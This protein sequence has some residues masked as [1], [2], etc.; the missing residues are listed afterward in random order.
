M[1]FECDEDGITISYIAVWDPGDQRFEITSLTIGDIE[2]PECANLEFWV[3]LT[4]DGLGDSNFQVQ[5][6][7]ATDLTFA[8]AGSPRAAEKL[9]GLAI[10][11]Y[12]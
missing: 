7:N 8:I 12:D 4:W 1:T 2:Q 9:I 5:T 3:H 10:A 11:M 6:D